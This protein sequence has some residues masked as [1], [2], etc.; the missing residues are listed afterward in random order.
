MLDMLFLSVLNMSITASFVILVVLLVRLFLRRAPK[1]FSYTLWAV[2]LFRLICPFSLESAVGFLPVSKTPIPQDIVYS[3]KPQIDTGLDIVD[4]VINPMLPVPNNTEDSI[5]PLQVWVFAGGVIWQIGI[6]V[7]LIYSIIQFVGLNRKLVGSTPLRDN[8]YLADHISSPFVM[9]VIKPHIYL[10]SSMNET[11]QAFVIAHEQ[12]HIKRFD[13][14]ARILAFIALTIH[15]FNPLAW[16]DFVLSGRDMEMSCDEAVMRGMDKDIR[17]DYAQSLLRF[18]TGR[19]FINATPLTFGEGNTKDRVKNVMNYKKPAFWVIALALIAVIVLCAG[20]ATSQSSGKT[21]IQWAKHLREADIEKI[22]LLVGTGVEKERYRLF[23]NDEFADI[24][25]LINES[26][27]TYLDN[28]EPV[29]GQSIAFYITTK[30]GERHTVMNI[31][32]NYLTIDG[33]AYAAGYDWLSSWEYSKGNAMLP[34]TFSF[35]NGPLL[36]LD[37]LKTIAQKGDLVS[38]EDFAPFD[39]RDVGFGLYIMNY[40]MEEPYY[41]MVGGVPGE[42]PMYVR[43]CSADTGQSLD[44]RNYGI[45]NF[46][47]NITNSDSEVTQLNGQIVSIETMEND[48]GQQAL[49]YKITVLSDGAEM[50]WRTSESTTASA[51]IDGLAA[52]DVIAAA[53]S[54]ES[55]TGSP[56]VWNVLHIQF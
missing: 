22:E 26:S 19:R 52:G 39:G 16:L 12:Y 10:P 42:V 38:W 43:L 24:V 51:P 54:P 32:N 33:I 56:Q 45:D 29:S 34:P 37:E 17:A 28:P 3:A 35:G 47:G 4:K 36:T 25:K 55:V 30:D 53:C 2:V 21:P 31:G 41:V 40:P 5:N 1:I 23:T 48:S 18:A 49:L 9:G 46:I 27:G 15:W 8:I 44:I 14:I 13:H 20:L 6:F 50:V 7:M 11:E